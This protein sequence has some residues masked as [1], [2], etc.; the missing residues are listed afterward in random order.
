MEVLV[1][2]VSFGDW[3]PLL[4]RC[5]MPENK[6]G[7]TSNLKY[8]TSHNICLSA[9]LFS[10]TS[11]FSGPF[12]VFLYLSTRCPQPFLLPWQTLPPP[13]ALQLHHSLYLS[14]PAH[15]PTC[16]SFPH[17]LST[18]YQSTSF[19]LLSVRP[20]FLLLSFCHLNLDLNLPA[21]LSAYLY[22]LICSCSSLNHWNHPAASS[23]CVWVLSLLPCMNGDSQSTRPDVVC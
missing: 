7:V 12:N 23:V 14:I 6:T 21:C 16:I 19:V 17:Q 15:L 18:L 1:D 9:C 2:C 10:H 20:V 4:K 13:S 8:S 22:L 5:H 3:S 11:T